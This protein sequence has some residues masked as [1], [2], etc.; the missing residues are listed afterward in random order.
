MVN[1]FIIERMISITH[2]AKS[3]YTMLDSWH[4]RAATVMRFA[5]LIRAIVSS[6]LTGTSVSFTRAAYAL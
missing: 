3:V 5:R 1:L 4:F 2:T 6:D